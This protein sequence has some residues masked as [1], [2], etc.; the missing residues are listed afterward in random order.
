MAV[1]TLSGFVATVSHANNFFPLLFQSMSVTVAAAILAKVTGEKQPVNAKK[2]ATDHS[3]TIDVARAAFDEV[4][5]ANKDKMSAVYLV[6][7][8]ASDFQVKVQLVPAASLEAHCSTLSRVISRSIFALYP[9]ASA[10]TTTSD[11]ASALSSAY[12]QS[13]HQERVQ[14]RTKDMMVANPLRTNSLSRVQTADITR[15]RGAFALPAALAS[16]IADVSNAFAPV[17]GSTLAGPLKKQMSIADAFRSASSSATQTAASPTSAS[18]ASSAATPAQPLSRT[19]SMG[20][21]RGMF[22]SASISSASATAASVSGPS[23][24]K[25]ASEG[26][27]EGG[28]KLGDDPFADSAPARKPSYTMTSSSSSSSSRKPAAR[29]PA[30]AASKAKGGKKGLDKAGNVAGL[31]ASGSDDDSGSSS[32]SDTGSSLARRFA[33]ASS[34]AGADGEES[35]DGDAFVARPGPGAAGGS[36][37]RATA[38]DSDSDA[39][40]GVDERAIRAAKQAEARKREIAAAEADADGFDKDD[41]DGRAPLT[42]A[43]AAAAAVGRKGRRSMVRDAHFHT[44]LLSLA[45]TFISVT[46]FLS[47]HS[48][49]FVF[50]LSHSSPTTAMTT[51]TT[52][53]LRLPASSLRNRPLH[54]RRRPPPLP[55]RARRRLSRSSSGERR[56]RSLRRK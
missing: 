46:L 42:G 8:I 21:L 24:A 47:D 50:F 37:R 29:K 12:A 33:P 54:G 16:P 52:W 48:H 44:L 15:S 10:E 51:R 56:R 36:V 27:N 38:V 30:A 40:D 9:T 20:G 39:G 53:P 49:V 25:P 17:S 26:G 34:A 18:A 2:A 11:A 31:V 6:T 41:D 22:A 45:L 7:G 14:Y 55:T 4:Y 35:D 28:F 43:A 19:A 3:V 13:S 5:S 1:L 23:V 32:E